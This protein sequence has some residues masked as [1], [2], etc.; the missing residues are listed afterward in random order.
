MYRITDDHGTNRVCWTWAEAISW[1]AACSAYVHISNRFTGRL[2]A[3][4][5]VK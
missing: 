2:L 3:T 5:I 4:R 1:T